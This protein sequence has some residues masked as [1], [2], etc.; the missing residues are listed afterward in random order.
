MQYQFDITNLEP[1]TL[2]ATEAV[3]PQA[4]IP[5]RIPTLLATL[6]DWLRE[7]GTQPAG[8]N[9]AVYDRFGPDGMRMRIGIPV[10]APFESGGPVACTMLAGGRVAHTRHLGAY[11]GLPN[12]HTQLNEWC[13][14]HA[15]RPSGEAWEVYGDWNPDPARLVT[16]VYIRLAD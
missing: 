2:A 4:E 6:H 16:D 10:S 1:V 3:L 8:L 12:A 14:A 7:T 5:L 9:H 13:A 11:D 15:L